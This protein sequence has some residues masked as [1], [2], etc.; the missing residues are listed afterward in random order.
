MAKGKLTDIKNLV[1]KTFN[2]ISYLFG[3][4]I[5]KVHF[6]DPKD[7]TKQRIVTALVLIPIALYAILSAKNLFIF[8]S[9]AIAILMTAEWLDITKK[10]QDQQKWRIIGLFYI[11]IPIYSVIK[12]RLFDADILL[13]MFAVIWATDIFAFFAGKTLGGPKLA[14]AISPSK[15]WSGLGGGVVASMLIGLMSSFMFSGGVVF[16]IFISVFLSFVEQA[17]D[18]FESKVKRIF[19]VKDSGNIIPGHGGVLDRLDGMMFVAPVVLFLI[20][21]FSDKF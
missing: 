18:L 2:S 19:G 14:P 12:I 10:A 17:S 21:F 8:L 5:E 4:L 13:W 15:T 3:K 7:N 6:L 9:I 20:T 11:L 16:F 1:E